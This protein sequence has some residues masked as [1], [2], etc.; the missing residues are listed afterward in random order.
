MERNSGFSQYQIKEVN[1]VAS[2][3][4]STVRTIR[5]QISLKLRQKMKFERHANH[6]IHLN[7]R[8]SHSVGS[9][10]PQLPRF[11]SVSFSTTT[12]R[13]DKNSGY[14]T[15]DGQFLQSSGRNF[16][17]FFDVCPLPKCETAT[18]CHTPRVSRANS[19][20]RNLVKQKHP[21]RRVIHTFGSSNH[22]WR[23][24]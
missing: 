17:V 8:K 18:R 11:V 19:S 6:Q 5:T 22:T 20:G 2:S 21:K 3:T 13:M 23:I 10:S 16:C 15:T 12:R 7:H 24:C 1:D 14:E 4:S 9:T